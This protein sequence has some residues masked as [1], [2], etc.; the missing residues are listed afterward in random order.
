MTDRRFDLTRRLSV[1]VQPCDSSLCDIY[2]PA[3]LLFFSSVVDS[4]LVW[5]SKFLSWAG[6]DHSTFF[7]HDMHET[8]FMCVWLQHALGSFLPTL[9]YHVCL[10][11]PELPMACHTTTPPPLCFTTALTIPVPLC[12]TH[13]HCYTA[14]CTHTHTPLHTYCS[15]ILF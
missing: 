3:L 7:P 6:S 12:P 11:L 2:I 9:Y 8:W 10:P 13:T 1:D 5:V 14:A 4:W 15:D